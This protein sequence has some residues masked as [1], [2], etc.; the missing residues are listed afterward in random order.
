MVS[1]SY[2]LVVYRI[3]GLA[4]SFISVGMR[5]MMILNVSLN[6]AFERLCGVDVIGDS[7]TLY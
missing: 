6:L 2:K 5:Y 1:R 3:I 4:K 7:I